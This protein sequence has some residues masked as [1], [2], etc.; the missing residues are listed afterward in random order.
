MVRRR[1][2]RRRSD[3]ARANSALI[4]GNDSRTTRPPMRQYGARMVSRHPSWGARKTTFPSASRIS[5]YAR[6]SF[7]T[8]RRISAFALCVREH[9][10]G[11]LFGIRDANAVPVL[12][13][14][15]GLGHVRRRRVVDDEPR[16]SRA[17]VLLLREET[18][19]LRLVVV[20]H[21]RRHRRVARPGARHET[22]VFML[23][24]VIEDDRRRHEL[25]RIR[26][27]V[28]RPGWSRHL[29]RAGQQHTNLATGIDDLDPF[30]AQRRESFDAIRLLRAH[31]KQGSDDRGAG[32]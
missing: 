15:L 19:G 18:A 3:S 12:L 16:E 9:D 6:S 30:R 23:S 17:V 31:E 25:P 14:R 7:V 5:R 27:I 21:H 32:G 28:I 24:L 11:I 26:P 29:L 22:A 13:H 2:H 1:L 20:E 10:L 8:R 4:V